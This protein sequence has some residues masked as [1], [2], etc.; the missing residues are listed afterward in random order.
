LNV[1]SGNLFGLGSIF[2]NGKDKNKKKWL[3]QY[4]I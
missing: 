1:S 4:V 2:F 3:T